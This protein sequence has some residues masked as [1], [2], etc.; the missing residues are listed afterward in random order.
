HGN[1]TVTCLQFNSQ[2]IVSGSDDRC[3][4]VYNTAS[5]K[6]IH[7][8]EGH[9]ENVIVT[10]SKDCTLKAWRLPNLKVDK[11]YYFTKSSPL[12]DNNQFNNNP[13]FLHTFCGHNKSVNTLSC[14]RN[15]LI[16]G[17]DDDDTRKRCI[18]KNA[19]GVIK[20]WNIED[21]TQLRTLNLSSRCI[22][23]PLLCSNPLWLSDDYLASITAII[24]IFIINANNY[25]K[26]HMFVNPGKT[27]QYVVGYEIWQTHLQ[28]KFD[29]QRC[30]AAVQRN[31]LETWFEVFDFKVF[32]IKEDRNTSNACLCR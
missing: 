28:V 24:V 29:K 4:N 16:S 22:Y 13:Y 12:S 19:D 9:E 15:T 5:G 21:G 30:V 8:L 26:K 31:N 14:L 25:K 10:G 7:K 1:N 20:F 18:S 3:I 11:S 23:T 2:K 6:M 32:G 27:K 17:S